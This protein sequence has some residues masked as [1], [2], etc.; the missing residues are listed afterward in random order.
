MC[1][2]LFVEDL[3]DVRTSF[4]RTFALSALPLSARLL[5]ELWLGV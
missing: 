1:E 5:D 3:S 4:V 2:D